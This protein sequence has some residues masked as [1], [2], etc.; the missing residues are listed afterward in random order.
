MLIRIVFVFLALVIASVPFGVSARVIIN[1]VAWMGSPVSAADEWIEIHN[2][3]DVAVVLDGWI[4]ED[5]ASLR[6]PL[7]GVIEPHSYFLLERTDD[8]SVPFVSADAIYAGTLRNNGQ[9]LMLKNK[10]GAVVDTFNASRGWPAGDNETK[11]TAQWVADRWITARGTPRDANAKPPPEKVPPLPGK[12]HTET[13]SHMRTINSPVLEYTQTA[14]TTEHSTASA[15]PQAVTIVDTGADDD[16]PF[17][18]QNEA[19]AGASY[20]GTAFHWMTAAAAL[21]G[22]G[23]AASIAN[24]RAASDAVSESRRSGADSYTITE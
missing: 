12:P 2:T 22:V 13:F 1:E 20:R 24:K 15:T 10:T 8:D 4:L 7:E 17:Y 21:I 11:D 9:T 3:D 6:I 14:S 19:R 5:A 16:I 18:T 23:A